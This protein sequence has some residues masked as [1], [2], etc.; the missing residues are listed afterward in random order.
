MPGEGRPLAKD[1]GGLRSKRF[2]TTD[3]PVFLRSKTKHIVED[4]SDDYLA[5]DESRRRNRGEEDTDSSE[6]DEPSY[7]SY[8][9]Q[10]KPKEASDTDDDSSPTI[11]VSSEQNN[12]LKWKS[13][14]LNRTVKESP[15]NIDTWLELVNHQ[16]VLLQAGQD[17]DGITTEN[18]AH[19]Y[20]EIK[21]S[22]LE[23]A[24]S[25]A[26]KPDDKQRILVRLMQEGVKVWN[27]KVATKK[28]AEV[29]QDEEYS[30]ELWKTHLDFAMSSITSF[31]Y[32]DVKK[33]L[34]DRLHLVMARSMS[35][36]L[37][38]K[39]EEIIYVF[40][41]LT[42]LLH[43]AGY[44]ESAVAAWQC[45]LDLNFFRPSNIESDKWAI[46]ILGEFW[47]TELPR[48]G[49]PEARG[50]SHYAE[51]G[52]GE[53]VE[54][55]NE[56]PSDTASSRDSYKAWG[57]IERSRSKKARMPA[58]ALDE[59][60]DDDPFR[61]VIFTDIENLMFLIPETVLPSVAEQLI[62]AF[63]LFSGYP[64]A[65]KS[66]K[67]TDMAYNDQFIWRNTEDLEQETSWHSTGLDPDDAEV[68]P[69]PFDAKGLSIA[70]PPDL[71][72]A[73]TA[74]NKLFMTNADKY[75]V[76]ME[77][78]LNVTK[79]L[80]L[81]AK[82]EKLGCYHLALS[83]CHDP[84]NVKKAAKALLKQYPTNA[85]LYDAY[86]MAEVASGRLEIGSKVL[87]SAAEVPMVCTQG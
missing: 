54:P 12:P 70:A 5:V 83:F 26:S 36:P 85:S 11:D 3:Q 19:S 59:G 49:E 46:D 16:D 9:G 55:V 71:L 64:P 39:F 41:R 32:D 63:L 24:L 58:R 27:T 77:T 42:C 1:H 84:A 61:V 65:F 48:I 80:V 72:F 30:F 17:I 82:V 57:F 86:A 45:I 44:K 78:V 52:Q 50:L 34:V 69:P 67:W 76:S 33:M 2:R 87:S 6:D 15:G 37:Q 47:E 7:R 66:S 13:I 68:R 4:D 53:P 10:E 8:H 62:D 60:T 40:L 14:Q 22:M 28:W 43:D 21:L 38:T 79:Q 74:W 35:T 51:T 25:N 73:S 18:E 31:Q 20:A 23:S 81:K 29:V 56:Q 75:S